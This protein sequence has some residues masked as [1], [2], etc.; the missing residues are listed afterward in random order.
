MKMI[1]HYEKKEYVLDNLIPEVDMKTA[2]PE[3]I[4]TNAK[5]VDD[6]TKVACIIIATMTLEL[7]NSYED[8]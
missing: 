3:E 1:L 5:H 7:Q 6:A 4:A 2:T 8:Y